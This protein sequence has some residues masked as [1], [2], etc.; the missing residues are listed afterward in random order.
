M[1]G[2]VHAE[3]QRFVEVGLGREAWEQVCAAAGVIGGPYYAGRR[4]PD[5]DLQAIVEAA[6]DLSERPVPDLLREFGD[7]LVDG[8]LDVYGGFLEPGWSA[9]DLLENVEQVIHR[10]VR[11][12][13]PLADPPRLKVDRRTQ[14]DVR[15]VYDSPR[16]LC[17]LAEGLIR[18]VARHYGEPLSVSQE[19]C[20]H[21]GAPVCELRVTRGR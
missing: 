3:L 18:G 6:S 12:Q 2:I 21:T 19:R 11:L 14:A 10:V 15:I 1:H 17:A 20:M 5:E 16:R 13:N 4:Y 9:F 8:L 7:F